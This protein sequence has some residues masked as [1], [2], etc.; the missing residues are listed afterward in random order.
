M[1]TTST[2]TALCRRA[3]LT[4]ALRKP[5]AIAALLVL[6]ILPVRANVVLSEAFP[7]PHFVTYLKGLAYQHN[8]DT[9]DAAIADGIYVPN[10]TGNYLYKDV[11]TEQELGLIK[12]IN[13]D[14]RGSDP[15]KVVSDLTGIKLLTNLDK[16]L[17]S[18]HQLTSLDVSGMEKIR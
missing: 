11:W 15:N 14:G 12:I 3:H 2:L 8:K 13:L 16:L 9:I 7:D 1:K 6:A 17:V 10:K 5:L 18:G 4:T